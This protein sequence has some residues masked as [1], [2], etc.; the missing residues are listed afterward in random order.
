MRSMDAAL[1]IAQNVAHIR[2]QLW[3]AQQELNR[4]RKHDC[5]LISSAVAD[6]IAQIYEQLWL[7]QKELDRARMTD[8]YEVKRGDET[9]FVLPSMKK[10][11][12]K[13]KKGAR[14][15]SGKCDG[16]GSVYS[17]LASTLCQ[18]Q[19]LVETK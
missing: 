12:K 1:E 10:R 9:F 2:E 15:A 5:F 17:G 3:L 11:Y 4:V 13:T 18:N 8:G 19:V 6:N 14:S 7:A 16:V